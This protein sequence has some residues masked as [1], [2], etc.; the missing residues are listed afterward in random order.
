MKTGFVL[1]LVA[2]LALAAPLPG[3]AAP[4]APSAPVG[5]NLAGIYLFDVLAT[6]RVHRETL[7]ALFRTEKGVPSWVRNIPGGKSFVSSP[8]EEVE[9]EGVSMQV[10]HVCK[11]HDCS[12]NSIHILFTADGASAW[13]RLYQKGAQDRYFGNP[14]AAQRAPLMQDGL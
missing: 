6:S 3:P 8:S 11:P 12:D 5:P 14:S 10:F 2:S 13:A 9:I 4:L 7:I 1:A